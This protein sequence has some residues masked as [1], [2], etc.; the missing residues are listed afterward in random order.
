M[1]NNNLLLFPGFLEQASLLPKDTKV[2]LFKC[3]NYLCN[4]PKH[5]SLHTKKVKGASSNVFEC[6]VDRCVRLIFDRVDSSLRCWYVGEHDTTLKLA[7]GTG[8]SVDDIEIIEESF[9]VEAMYDFIETNIVNA[10]FITSQLTEIQN[11][12]S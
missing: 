5:P 9:A 12:L 3:L 8:I 4:D 11:H 10:E 7:S 1:S 2:K 6:R